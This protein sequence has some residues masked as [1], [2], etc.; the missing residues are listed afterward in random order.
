MA[1]RDSR[2]DIYIQ[3]A[4]RF[5]KPVL[6][7]FRQ[8]VHAGCPDVHETMK[9]NTP[10]FEYKGP[11]A[12]MAAFNAH[13]RVGFWKGRLIAVGDVEASYDAIGR[14][15]SLDDLPVEKTLLAFVKAATALNERGVKTPRPA[16]RS[17]PV[18]VP[19][20]VMKA[21]K[22]HK[23]ALANFKAFPPSHKREYIDWITD[24]KTKETRQRRLQTMI[25]W[26]AEGKSHNWKYQKGGRS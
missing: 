21:L 26:V 20:F 24:A 1:T 8:I 9:W 4:P 7:H 25:E 6:R 3:K 5:A 10:A 14:V 2:I 19:L 17:T 13:C 12:G 16:K 11:L 23:K 15:E 22:Q 18:T